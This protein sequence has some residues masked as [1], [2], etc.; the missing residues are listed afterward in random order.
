M[1]G[2]VNSFRENEGV[3]QQMLKISNKVYIIISNIATELDEEI[4]YSM[5]T[6]KETRYG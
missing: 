4:K 5:P 2:R 3:Y 1:Q 6:M